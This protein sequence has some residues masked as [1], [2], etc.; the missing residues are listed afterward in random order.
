MNDLNFHQLAVYSGARGRSPEIQRRQRSRV[1][2]SGM[3][4]L[5]V[6]LYD[7]DPVTQSPNED[8]ADVE[9]SFREGQVIKVYG[10]KDDDG[11]FK[12]AIKGGKRGLVPCNMIA[13]VD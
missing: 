5:F 6:A 8:A 7:Y 11:F 3:P 4:R 1:K 13:Q 2:R 12:G 10:E 9:L